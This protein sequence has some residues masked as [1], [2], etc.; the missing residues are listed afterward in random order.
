MKPRF[1][2]LT[3]VIVALLALFG[4]ADLEAH[5]N[6]YQYGETF[7]RMI[8]AAARRFPILRVV[9]VAGGVVLITHLGW[10]VP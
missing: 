5:L 10:S 9:I 1:G 7:S 6:R 3:G 2:W 4:V 8:Q